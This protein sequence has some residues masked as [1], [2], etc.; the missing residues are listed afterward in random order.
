MHMYTSVAADLCTIWLETVIYH[1]IIY[2]Y[3][4]AVVAQHGVF[5]HAIHSCTV[6]VGKKDGS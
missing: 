2:A 5:L 6:P 3:M 1:T 4:A